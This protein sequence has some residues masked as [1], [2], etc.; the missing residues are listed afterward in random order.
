MFLEANGQCANDNVLVGAAI[1]PPCPGSTTAPCVQGGQY[2]LVNVVAGNV[3]TFS[4]CGGAA[5]DTQ[6]TIYN[7]AGGGS[8]GY[9]DDACG[10]Q[11]TVNWTATFTGQLRVLVDLY[12]C[13]NNATCATLT[14][15]CVPPP[16]PPPN[17]DPCGATPLTVNTTCSYS[18][19]SNLGAS[20][21]TGPPAPGCANYGGGDVWF[22]AVVPANGRLVFDTNVG[23][24]TDSGMA[25]YTSTGGCAGPFTLLEC[26]DD[27]SGNGLMSFVDRS[28]LTPGSTVYIRV[29][30]Y[31]NNT[32]G[33]F[34]I[35]AYS[36]PPPPPMTGDDPCGANPL[37]VLLSCVPLT[38]SNIGAT[39]TVG[40]PAPGCGL[41]TG[42]D[43]WFTFTAPANGMVTIESSTGTMTNGAMEL[44][45]APSCAGPFTSLQCN[46]DAIG[47]M[48][49]IDRR[50]NPLTPGQTYYIRFW[51]Y[52]GMQGSFNIC[53]FQG[54]LGSTVPE[55]CEGG[56]TICNS[57]TFN[58]NTT[59]TGC[60]ADLTAANQGCLTAGERQGTW[61]YFSP[62]A[63]GTIGFTIAPAVPT[64]YD[65]AVWGPMA[66]VT[67]PPPGPPLRCSWAAPFGPTGCGNGATDFSEG[68]GG[69]RWVS[70]FDVLVGEI[71]ILYVDNFSTNGQQFSLTWGLT[72][73]ASLD[74]TVLPLE[75]ISLTALPRPD[76]ILL[77]W[78]TASETNTDVFVI[79]R[80]AD[81][82][83]F[84][85][86]GRVAAGGNSQ[87]TLYYAYRDDAPLIGLNYYRLTE[88]D[89]DGHLQRSSTVWTVFNT[90]VVHG[91]PFPNP[92]VHQ[93]FVELH[94]VNA[95]VIEVR[96]VDVL[97]RV[98]RSELV[99]APAG[100]FLLSV[101]IA[102]LPSGGYFLELRSASGETLTKELIV[103]Y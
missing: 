7:N 26:D 97:G 49:R 57:Q 68:A 100:P 15:N 95:Q 90:D 16:V 60:V 102:L 73:G 13:A 37:P 21:T 5:F 56:V 32:F 94:L 74:C 103:K 41:Y 11:S 65:F 101:D 75:L 12:N 99:P 14:I 53:V 98:V 22:T 84:T 54:S 36:P 47:F 40:A 33:G 20:A 76:H 23:D 44:Y 67:C 48:P 87:S 78:Y 92:T 81:A 28:G 96:V 86:I 27:D 64:D 93:A 38:Y 91:R 89:R 71:Y 85:E 59:N 4:T 19:S 3:Y 2:A 63:A 72:N 24:I 61:Y 69:D 88:M 66:S 45:A 55:D 6:I 51:G 43:I 18:S 25:L 52:N 83:E 46:D 1:T 35:C 42:A 62:S 29:W 10:L 82:E 9:S 77:E 34:E 8:L 30:E 58:N 31:G 80:S 79:E 39:A 70:T 50:C 17:D